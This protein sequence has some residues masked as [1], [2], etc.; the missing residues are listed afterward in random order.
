MG[1]YLLPY[2]GSS[3]VWSRSI[4]NTGGEKAGLF[5]SFRIRV[6]RK[7]LMN[8]CHIL[9]CYPWGFRHG[10][11]A[12]NPFYLF[13]H[14]MEVS[15]ESSWK[16]NCRSWI[17]PIQCIIIAE[18]KIH[19]RKEVPLT[20]LPLHSTCKEIKQGAAWNSGILVRK[21]KCLWEKSNVGYGTI[22]EGMLLSSHLKEK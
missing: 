12:W 5:G 13:F 1:T 2:G 18:T 9:A 6:L 22:S 17:L 4:I 7:A 8:S 16:F 20:W 3:V 10:C 19:K 15:T 21:I 14:W 11:L